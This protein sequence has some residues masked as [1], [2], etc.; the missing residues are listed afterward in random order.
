MPEPTALPQATV[1]PADLNDQQREAVAHLHGPLLGPAPVGTGKTTVIAHRAAHAIRSGIDPA[2]I[3]CLSFTNRAAR[4]MRER[5]LALLR[6]VAEGEIDAGA[7]L[8]QLA[9]PPVEVLP[10][11]TIDDHRSRRHGY[12]EVIFASGKT[13]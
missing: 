3:L 13:T 1:L 9:Q 2:H 11:A 4:E 5:V 7:A 10:F 12:P 8:D 6:Q